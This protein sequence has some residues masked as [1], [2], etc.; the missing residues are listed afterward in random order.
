MGVGANQEYKDMAIVDKPK[1]VPGRGLTSCADMM[2][3]FPGLVKDKRVSGPLVESEA[4]EN[5]KMVLSTVIYPHP[6]AGNTPMKL[7]RT[8]CFLACRTTSGKG[9][10]NVCSTVSVTG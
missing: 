6:R 10:E 3:S 2:I 7:P 8:T 9:R 1:H 5:T 4:S